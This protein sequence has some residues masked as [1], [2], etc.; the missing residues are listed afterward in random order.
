MA[1][2]PLF[3]VQENQ[4]HVWQIV[5]CLRASGQRA[6]ATRWGSPPDGQMR[7]LAVRRKTA[8]V[9]PARVVDE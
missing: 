5:A 3:L 8:S 1:M 9:Q 2:A 7:R 6:T 4:R